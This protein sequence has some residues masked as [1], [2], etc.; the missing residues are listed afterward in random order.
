MENKEINAKINH[1]FSSIV[2]DVLDSVLT[3]YE[4]ERGSVIALTEKRKKNPWFYRI[5]SI[6]AVFVIL[7]SGFFGFSYYQN[8]YAV[9]ST[10]SLDVNPSIEINV[11]R[12]E[13]VL[14]T[15]ALN[16]DGEVVMGNMDLSGS[17]L[18]V[19]VNAVI[20]SMLR[21]G[22]LSELANSILVSVDH[23]DP[24]KGAELQKKLAREIDALLRTNNFSGAV[25]SQTISAEKELQKL[26]D[27]YG[28][29]IGKA[30][31]IRRIMEKNRLH[32]FEDLVSLSIN[33]LN[34]LCSSGARPG[35]VE[36]VGKA[37]DK[38]YIGVEEAKRIAFK[39]A[40]LAASETTAVEVE[41]DWEDG[42][43]VYE[44]EFK[45]GGYEYEYE[46]NARTGA[47]HK[48]KK[49]RDDD[50]AA[51]GSSAKQPQP[52]ASSGY[53]GE[54]KAKEISLKHAGLSAGSI[55][56]YSIELDCED[57]IAV[58]EVEFKAGGYEYEYGIDARTGAIREFEKERDD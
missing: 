44:V 50:Y 26:A 8:N 6:A 28:I 41:M 16:E 27:T 35:Q 19:A 25:L 54:A 45:Y 51:A 14:G 23:N 13:R 42:A 55:R 7:L 43:M 10:I 15:T 11:N 3:T 46:I 2:P 21:H 32:R 39:H 22:Y 4:K 12:H 33:E 1:A 58:Y 49:E 37:S 40:G 20:G 57:G 29:T 52:P 47:I 5:S 9:E 18:E 31:L 38:A 48:H 17:H 36:S 24:A 30:Q 53:I 34:L 56:K